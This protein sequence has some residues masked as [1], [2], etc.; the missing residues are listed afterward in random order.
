VRVDFDPS[1][2]TLSRMNETSAQ[3]TGSG[4]PSAVRSPAEERKLRE[5]KDAA[6]EFEQ[7]FAE[8]MLKSMRS[9]ATAEDESNAMDVYKGLL[10]TEYAKA[11]TDG[12]GLGIQDMV[13]NWMRDSD[14]SLKGAGGVQQPAVGPSGIGAANK[15]LQQFRLQ[16]YQAQ[17]AL[18]LLKE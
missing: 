4:S 10:D 18:P 2:L 17:A 13:L 3:A 7:M 12:G 9:T 14:P 8:I 16:Q 15:A 5:A 11:M 6:R 1:N